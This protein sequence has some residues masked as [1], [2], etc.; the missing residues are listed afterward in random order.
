MPRGLREYSPASAHWVPTKLKAHHLALLGEVIRE[1]RVPC[2]QLDGRILRPLKSDSLIVERSGY[3]SATPA[4]EA[5]HRAGKPE[6]HPATASNG[7]PARLSPSQ[8]QALRLICRQSDSVLAD[9]LDGRVLK[10]LKVRGLVDERDGWVSPTVS[11]RAHFDVVRRRRR[12]EPGFTSEPRSVR[13]EIILRHVE[14]LERAIR[15]DEESKVGD[16]PAF[17]D[18]VLEGLRQYARR[19]EVR[20]ATLRT[21]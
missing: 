6:R 5:L 21:T 8:E 2:V 3:V 14:G 18:D 16:V 20:P 13:A 4:G 15:G 12:K 7:T 19:L 10:A 17:A 9:R 1:G 11:G